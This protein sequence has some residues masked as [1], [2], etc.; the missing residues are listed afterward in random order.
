MGEGRKLV[1]GCSALLAAFVLSTASATASPPVL[2]P[3]LDQRGILN[4]AHQG[5][6]T[7]A[8]SSTM[9][10]FRTALE[11]RGADLLEL[12][13]N[14]T[15]DDRLAVMHDHYTS[16]VTEADEQVRH[17]TLAQVQALDA[18]YWFS[19]GHG[20]F[21]H[22]LPAD[23]YPLRGVRTGAKP[24][25]TGFTAED[26]RVP[27]ME[28]VLDGFPGVPINI[29]I[30]PVPGEPEQV[31][32]SAALVAELMNRPEYRN[33]RVIVAS[34]DQ[35]ALEKFHELAP[36]VGVSAS[37]GSMVGFLGGTP[38]SPRPV[39]LQVPMTLG[40]LEPPKMLQEMNVASMGFAVHTWTDSFESEN[41]GVYAHL[42]D[43]GVQGI[44][45]SS[46]AKLHDYLC[47]AGERRPNGAPR[48]ARQVMKYRLAFPSRSLRHYL[49]HGLPVRANCDQACSLS[50]SVRV[51][52]KEARRLGIRQTSALTDRRGMVLI[53]TQ[54][55]RSRPGTRVVR[56]H[57][58]RQPLRRLTRA[59]RVTLEVTI[60]VFDSF[61]WRQDVKRKWLTLRSPRPLRRR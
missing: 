30:K 13:V 35:T 31:V 12:D 58:L 22:S 40:E 54:R 49:R 4:M 10:A 1:A 20:Q 7:E 41:D 11:E 23:Q 25:P 44:I 26:F 37:L 2:S 52:R 45:S 55:R 48:C 36:H 42:I 46:P 6:E 18:A 43:S 34:L 21:N 15:A 51:R 32:R 19:P 59:R 3:W 9:Y 50:L 60:N 8:P 14:V 17:L 29:E 53:G 39:A 56:A 61:G 27:S 33:R 57:A 47:R 24:P 5:G 16:R 28:E 38:I